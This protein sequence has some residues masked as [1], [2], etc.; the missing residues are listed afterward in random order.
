MDSEKRKKVLKEV[1]KTLGVILALFLPLIVLLLACATIGKATGKN[2]G[3]NIFFILALV[4]CVLIAACGPPWY[5]IHK[6][7]KGKV[8]TALYILLGLFLIC[9]R[10]IGSID[11]SLLANFGKDVL[12]LIINL[13]L[14]VLIVGGIV[15]FIY[16]LFEKPFWGI[17]LLA[18]AIVGTEIVDNWG[19]AQSRIAAGIMVL[20]ILC[21]VLPRAYIEKKRKD[22]GE[23]ARIKGQHI[24]GL[25]AQSEE[26]VKAIVYQDKI[27][28]KYTMSE[29]TRSF[30]H[31][32]GVSFRSER[33]FVGQTT[34]AHR[35]TNLTSAISL[36]PR[37][38]VT[39]TWIRTPETTYT[40]Q[41]N[42]KTYWYL[43]IDTD[44]G[45]IMLR[46]KHSSRLAEFVGQCKICIAQIVNRGYENE[47]EVADEDAADERYKVEDE[48]IDIDKMDGGTFEHFC[49]DLLRV[50]G[51]T[52]VRVTPASGDHGIDITAEK[53][54]I[55]WGFQCKRWGDTKVDAI[56]IGQTYKGKALYECDMVAVI[57]TSALTAQAEGEA[58]Q[59]G[60]K[61]WGRGK[62]RQLMSKLDNADDYYL[63][64]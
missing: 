34:I 60:I 37:G 8:K 14:L 24:Y 63:S 28:F 41:D 25:S 35:K 61:V 31:I 10:D 33:T 54:D 18:S 19:K 17:A 12:Y 23:L 43:S 7:A 57:T 5:L 49:A 22:N 27:V 44:E 2:Y 53:D 48:R 59:L 47:Y 51:W 40:T 3:N 26:T 29:E 20:I 56:A 30:Q 50:N 16:L 64:A 32:T 62:I 38:G 21:F 52:D 58:K 46:F 4:V 15:L 39:R 36:G 13:L 11:I 6:F 1:L 9:P 45:S 55:K 42:Y